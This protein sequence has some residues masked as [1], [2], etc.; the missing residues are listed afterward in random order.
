MPII[1][2]DIKPENILVHRVK[3]G[4]DAGSLRLKL[5]DFGWAVAMVPDSYRITLCGTPEYMPPEV[6]SEDAYSGAFDIWTLGILLFEMLAGTT[7]F[8]TPGDAEE[9]DEDARMAAITDRIIDGTFQVPGH[10]SSEAADLLHGMLTTDQDKRLRPAAIRRHP[11]MVRHCGEPAE[12]SFTPSTA[13][14]KLAREAILRASSVS[15]EPQSAAAAGAAGGAESEHAAPECTTEPELVR[16]EPA[17]ITS[18][19]APEP[20]PV[21]TTTPPNKARRVL[22]EAHGNPE[23]K[24]QKSK[25]VL[26]SRGKGS[27]QP[28]KVAGVVSKTTSKR[29][30]V[31]KQAGPATRTRSATSRMR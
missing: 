7:P 30:L 15:G 24:Q 10:I 4:P 12:G 5:A 28:V 22:V 19:P 18:E 9:A 27:G 21:A 14:T 2:R 6:V 11:W 29:T 3:S 23:G 20:T 17:S 1:H 16:S 25:Q 26:A 8:E 13:G 31:R